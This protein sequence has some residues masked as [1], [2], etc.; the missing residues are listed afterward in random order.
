[1]GTDQHTD[2]DGT[3]FDIAPDALVALRAD[4]TIA[5]ANQTAL[6]Q[7]GLP[8]T[9]YV[10]RPFWEQAG[11]AQ[12]IDLAD[13]DAATTSFETVLELGR[14]ERPV[15]YRMLRADGSAAWVEATA[16]RDDASDLVYTILRDVTDREN[17]EL[18]RLSLAFADAPLGMALVGTGGGFLRVNASLARML[19]V[20]ESDLLERRLVDV[21]APAAEQS[22]DSDALA[23]IVGS[24]QA[25]VELLRDDGRPTY[26]LLN[27]TPVRDAFGAPQHFVFQVLDMTERHEA[28]ARLAANESK[29][30]EA[31]QIARLGSWEWTSCAASTACASPRRP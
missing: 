29:L 6:E 5:R 13:R 10:G 25:E 19:G 31:Q 18:D 17:D 7:A 26:G 14:T 30:A 16:R 27:A 15:R 23:R 1:M 8:E 2:R 3:L 4:G 9:R 28:Q 20:G 21:V 11:V 24:L 12:K 22:W